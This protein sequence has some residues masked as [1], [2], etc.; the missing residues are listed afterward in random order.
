MGAK[1]VWLSSGVALIAFLL[2]SGLFVQTETSKGGRFISA[3]YYVWYKE[4]W[5]IND[6]TP[7]LGWYSSD[8]E[9]VIRTHL[10]WAR[11]AG[12]DFLTLSWSNSPKWYNGET[13]ITTQKVFDV[14]DQM[15]SPVKLAIMIEY[16][17]GEFLN[18]TDAVE[19]IY[20]KYASRPS[21]FRLYGKPLLFVYTLDDYSPPKW[22]DTRFTER[23]IPLEVPY[24]RDTF[25]DRALQENKTYEFTGV[26][27][28]KDNFHVDRNRTDGIYYSEIW[29][30]VIKFG[31]MAGEKTVIV[32]IATFNEWWEGTSIEPSQNYGFQFI[33]LTSSFAA[34]FKG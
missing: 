2:A 31:E 11:A 18:L 32:I 12:V 30:K 13:A 7:Q 16:W 9:S 27:P 33:N 6:D 8:N 15:S 21:Y 5:S 14:A 22:N 1:T 10:E 25:I 26:G 17:H 34:R 29:E 24:G 19:E 4:G 23:Y 28:H 20:S 3:Y